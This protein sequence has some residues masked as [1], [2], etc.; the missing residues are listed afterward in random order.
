MTRSWHR[1]LPLVLA[2]FIVLLTGC[3]SPTQPL[4]ARPTP[5]PV[6][7]N[8]APTETTSGST[9]LALRILDVGGSQQL[10]KMATDSYVAAHRDRVSKIEWVRGAVPDLVK[11]VGGEQAAGSLQTA[12]V[13]SGLD[14]LSLG[15]ENGLWMHLLPDYA[16][17]LPHP[18]DVYQE[19]A[20][21]LNALSDGLGLLAAYSP[22]GPLLEY[23][24]ASVP[25]A[26]H[27]PQALL[28]WARRNPGKFMYARPLNSGPARHFIMGLPYLL[29]DVEPRDPI[30]G[31]E[32]TWA[33]L[34][35]LDQAIEYYPTGTAITMKE[36]AEGTRWMIPTSTGWDV[37]QRA[38]GTL[39]AETR[40]ALFTS[41]GAHWVADGQF[42][43][44]PKGLDAGRLAVVLDL[45]TWVLQPEQQATTYETGYFYPGP[46]V[47]EIVP[48]MAPKDAQQ[49]IQE[50][51][52]PEIDDAIT[53]VPVAMPLDIQLMTA[54]FDKWDKLAGDKVK[55]S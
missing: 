9:P 1:V 32:K 40:V 38:I 15:A 49:L 21:R 3:A 24:S 50:F 2:A 7:T 10:L 30:H 13:A 46:A 41:P 22:S 27:S 20:Q 53:N 8:V 14:G 19:P 18:E 11:T 55:R 36:L 12:I 44:V 34:K 31:W 47:R 33:Y 25:D 52:R 6:S 28:D 51:S 45:M 35:E 17:K 43:L 39:P 26:P 37:N 42:L 4:V 54:F 5:R 16:D 29:G 48:A 23:A